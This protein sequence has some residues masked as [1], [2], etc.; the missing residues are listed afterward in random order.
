MAKKKKTA[1]VADTA[2][3]ESNP[4][5]T[6]VRDEP[7]EQASYAD[8]D[9]GVVP[10]TNQELLDEFATWQHEKLVYSM[11][12]IQR[13]DDYI[14]AYADSDRLFSVY[15]QELY[16]YRYRIRQ[17]IFD[18]NYPDL[19]KMKLPKFPIPVQDR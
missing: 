13:C 17:L 1:D 9:A 12:E 5:P 18:S 3:T 19:S 16:A 14:Q 15:K 2:T 11:L 8:V 6:P 10:K 4:E 7:T